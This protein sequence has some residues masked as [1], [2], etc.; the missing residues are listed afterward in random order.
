MVGMNSA[1]TKMMHT[2]TVTMRLMRSLRSFFALARSSRSRAAWMRASFC[3]AVSFCC[4]VPV[5]WLR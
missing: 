3:F 2:M 1:N 4:L 5:F